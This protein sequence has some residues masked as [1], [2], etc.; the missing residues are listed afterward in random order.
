M[1]RK[2]KPDL[3][4]SQNSFIP[5][6]VHD[7]S[8]RVSP[9][10]FINSGITNS[11]RTASPQL[12]IN[13]NIGT[14][15]RTV[16]RTITPV[17]HNNINVR[18]YKYIVNEPLTS[19]TITKLIYKKNDA[20]YI[21]YS[22]HLYETFKKD[23]FEKNN[24]HV[25]HLRNPPYGPRMIPKIISRFAE[26]YL[27]NIDNKNKYIVKKIFKKTNPKSNQDN[28]EV[29]IKN[30]KYINSHIDELSFMIESVILRNVDSEYLNKEH[31]VYII[32][33]YLDT[34]LSLG[35][36]LDKRKELIKNNNNILLNILSKIK[37][38]F[39]TMNNIG[40]LH[41]DLD[42]HLNNIMIDPNT[43]DIK[44]IDYG[45][46][47]IKNENEDK[48][49]NQFVH[50]KNMLLLRMINKLRLLKKQ[51]NV[52]IGFVFASISKEAI[53]SFLN[54]NLIDQNKDIILNIINE[55]YF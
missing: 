37:D 41:N 12:F 23:I 30:I 50:Q 16:S 39:N 28:V 10:L 3:K 48:F 42:Q 45:L 34:Y 9:E 25:Y 53:N 7:E 52:N 17:I 22:N 29:E 18:N 13:N 35:T 40:I 55:N 32:T 21:N 4:L 44:L 11:S 54:E 27:I 14:S 51:N 38:I 8:R 1:Y 15:S 24:I 20:S 33:P 6:S 43:M 47:I 5:I 26:I 31:N 49:N 19:N 36:Y 2:F 46:C